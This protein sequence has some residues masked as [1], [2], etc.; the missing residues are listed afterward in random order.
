MLL[1]MKELIVVFTS[2]WPDHHKNK[3]K[4]VFLMLSDKKDQHLH[5]DDEQNK[6]NQ[7]I[8]WLEFPDI[9]NL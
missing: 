9:L 5:Q 6:S 8:S 4:N 3:L 7:I 2:S 1:E